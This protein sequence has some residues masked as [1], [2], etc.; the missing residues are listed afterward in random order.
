MSGTEASKKAELIKSSGKKRKLIGFPGEGQGIL[1][2]PHYTGDKA[3]PTL[4]AVVVMGLGAWGVA[5]S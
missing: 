1:A 4:P 3:Q 2:V 5:Q